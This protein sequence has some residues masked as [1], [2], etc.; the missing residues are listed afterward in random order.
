MRTVGEYCSR[1]IITARPEHN[2]HEVAQR[3]RDSHV[4][5]VVV[6]E[7]GNGSQGHPVGVLTDRDL[8]VR[9]LAQTDQNLE[10]V[11]VDHIM[12]RP[13]VTVGETDELA[14]ALDVMRAAGVR[15][16]PVVDES[17]SVVGLLSF[18]DL[19]RHYQGSFGAFASLLDREQQEERR[20]VR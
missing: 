1:R 19:I 11:R 18:D 10:Q 4:G 7:S 9:V 6:I 8:V 12:T 5:C 17:N 2:L 15:R 16:L 13:A 3:M 14:D 20:A